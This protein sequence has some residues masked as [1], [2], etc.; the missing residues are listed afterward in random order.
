[1]KKALVGIWMLALLVSPASGLA[2]ETDAERAREDRIQELE[3]KLEVV[4]EELEKLRTEQAVPEELPLE[5]EYGLGPGASKIYAKDRG[6]SIGGYAEGLYRAFVDE[7]G[8]RQNTTDLLRLVTY[9]GYK[10]NDW[11]VFNSEVEIEHAAT[12]K[13]GSVSV[14]FATLDFLLHE[15]ANT[16][17]GLLLLPRFL[18]R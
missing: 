15:S 3:R 12:D 11:I 10:F 8:G 7:S 2:E 5:S 18:R 1:M 13:S 16:R 4:V 14:E 17:I 9:M 6:L